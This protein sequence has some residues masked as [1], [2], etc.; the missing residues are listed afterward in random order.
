VLTGKSACVRWEIFIL[1]RATIYRDPV[2]GLRGVH[3]PSIPKVMGM[4][5]ELRSKKG[6][7]GG[8]RECSGME[9]YGEPQS[10]TETDRPALTERCRSVVEKLL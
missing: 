7:Q 3:V 6:P 1:N 8:K 9:D 4:G 5:L 2:Q 10:R